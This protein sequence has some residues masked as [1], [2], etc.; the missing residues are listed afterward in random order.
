MVSY[1]RR[2]RPFT[3]R[4]QSSRWYPSRKKRRYGGQPRY[5]DYRYISNEWGRYS[6]ATTRV[7]GGQ[8]MTRTVNW[9]PGGQEFG[10][11]TPVLT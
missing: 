6:G 3:S 10:P 4:Y 1:R 7:Y 2:R 9:G 5:S 8:T 11:W